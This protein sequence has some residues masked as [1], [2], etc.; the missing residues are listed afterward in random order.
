[1]NIRG[2]F[3]RLLRRADEV[4]PSW[5]LWDAAGGGNR[6]TNWNASAITPNAQWDNPLWIR[7]RAEGEYR[8]NPLARR[9]VDCLVNA[10]WG[11]SALNPQFRDKATQAPW[12]LWGRNVDVSGR[13]DWTAVGALILQ[14]VVVS[15]ECFVRLVLDE[16]PGAVPLRLQI[17][18]PEFLDASRVDATT[19]AG[20]RYRGLRPEG[21]WLFQQNP[22]L[23]GTDLHSVFVPATD[24][25][26]IFRPVAPGAQRGQSWLAPVLLPL[27]ELN[28]Y[29]ESGLI[30]AKIAAL[31]TGFVRTP[32]GSNPLTTTPTTT[33]TLEPGSM[34]RLQ[35]GE[36][37]EFAQPPGIEDQF[38]PFVKTQMRRVA[39][40]MGIPYELLST[41]LSQVTF[42]SGRAGLLEFRRTV[43]TIQYGL[44]VPQFCE[45]VVRRWAALARALGVIEGDAEVSRWIG[46]VVQMLDQRA[47]V[48]ADIQR[49]RA[50]FCS[51]SEIVAQ[52]GWRVEDVD[53]EIAADNARAD[54]LG[55]VY[56]SDPR[57]TTLQGQEQPTAAPEA[58]Q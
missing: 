3:N 32:D 7:G 4:R 48:L 27:R 41:D 53:A 44:L 40:G 36:E 26:H 49:V 23:A 5:P 17:L 34:C 15:G 55:N 6:L 9:V 14:T 1:M 50:G 21:Y 22:A 43:E 31:F 11:A 25:L 58:Q 2:L 28:E 37:I 56:D 46:P 18:G 12:S 13:L 30:K 42:A 51:R 33:P 35:P 57:R 10:A 19:Y 38:D 16:E 39:A 20:I 47:E 29:L 45:P 8:N 24:C 54:R 52:S